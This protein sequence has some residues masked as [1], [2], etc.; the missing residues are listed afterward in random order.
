MTKSYPLGMSRD[1]GAA[2]KQ[3]QWI[4]LCM[5]L[6]ASRAFVGEAVHGE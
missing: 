5:H 3:L 1:S 4:A 2:S 6:T